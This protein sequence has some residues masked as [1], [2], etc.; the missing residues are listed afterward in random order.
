MVNRRDFL[1][2]AALSSQAKAAAT[3]RRGLTRERYRGVFAYPPTPFAEDLSLNEAALRRNIRKLIRIGVDGIVVGGST[4]EFYTLTDADHRRIA[5]ILV[6]ETRGTGAAGVIGAQGIN[7]EEVIRRTRTAM[8]A[9]VDAVLAMQPFYNPLT[10][11]EL[12]AFWNQLCTACPDIGVI[13]YHF[14]WVRQ[15]YPAETFRKL[16]ALPNLLGSKEAHY[17]FKEWRALQK[18]SPLVHMSATDAGWLVEMY[19]MGAPGVGSVNLSLMPHLIHRT[20][21]LCGE[22][23]FVEAERAFVPFTEG[24]GHLKSGAGR[25]FVFPSEL[26]FL[27]EYGGT[28]RSKALVESF[29]FLEA[30]PP[31]PPAIPVPVELRHRI[32]EYLDSRYPE[33]IPPPGFAET[34]PKGSKLWPRRERS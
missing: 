32:R 8:E 15:D 25:P 18:D 7:P 17:N 34:V 33:L 26:S 4:G 24:V 5:G 2:T 13:I 1:I 22:G 30:G 20:L 10:Q 9:G 23:K 12:V 28:A 6:E 19:R 29:G 27:S 3:P 16:A 11:R 31:R 14:E 21:Q